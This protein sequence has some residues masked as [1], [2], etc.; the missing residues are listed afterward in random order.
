[1]DCSTPGLPVLHHLPELAL[2]RYPPLK[3]Q[4][5]FAPLG[6]CSSGI[7]RAGQVHILQQLMATALLE[8]SYLLG[9]Y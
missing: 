6:P 2:W 7:V 1:M 3:I 9:Y 5:Y 4:A 8:E